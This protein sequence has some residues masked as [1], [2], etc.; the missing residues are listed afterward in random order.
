MEQTTGTLVT[1]KSYKDGIKST[2]GRVN[3]TQFSCYLYTQGYH[4]LR[5]RSGTMPLF[6]CE[7]FIQLDYKQF[8]ET[9]S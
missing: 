9:Q 6:S 5:K 7:L 3:M 2:V 1:S 4:K 8:N